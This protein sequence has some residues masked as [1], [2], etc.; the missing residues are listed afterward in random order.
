M[1]S[2]KKTRGWGSCFL[3][4]VPDTL[5][6]LI[7]HSSELRWV[8]FMGVSGVIGLTCELC[9]TLVKAIPFYIP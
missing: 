6:G 8:M 4:Y 7:D 9:L 2:L 3:T 5:E 1:E